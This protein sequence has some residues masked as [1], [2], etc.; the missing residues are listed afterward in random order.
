MKRVYIV[1]LNW[2]GWRDTIECLESVFRLDYPDFRV[3]VCDNDSKDRSIEYIKAWAN[4]LL[5]SYVIPS[6]PLRELSFPP[7]PKPI[8]FI[9]YERKKAE[10]GANEDDDAQLILIKNGSNSGFAAGNNVGLRYILAK[11]KFDYVWLLNN[12]T[13]I[14]PDS[15]LWMVKQMEEQTNAGIC[16][17]LIP[18]YSMPDII[19]NAGGGTFNKWLVK[20]AP[21]DYGKP[22]S[23]LS[24]KE[25]IESSLDYI[26]GASMLVRADFLKT[27]GLLNEK[28]FIYFE[29]IDWRIRSM[30]LYTMTYANRAIVY[31]KVGKDSEQWNKIASKTTEKF[32]FKSQ[33]WFTLR[34]MP[35]VLPIVLIN[36]A[37]FHL[38]RLCLQIIHAI[39]IRQCRSFRK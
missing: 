15:L 20:L 36:I 32:Y 24:S 18:F 2:N 10:S 26:S 21:I 1:L 19:C 28:Y 30:K 33:F 16:G 34:F 29:E 39:P 12:D 23:E 5:N 38:K 4:G 9:E 31:H 14:K 13:V 22:I 11:N 3:I 17:S 27:V 35:Y 37:K 6:N 25:E 8:K 7:V